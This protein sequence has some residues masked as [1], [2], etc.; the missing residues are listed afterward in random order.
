M[1]PPN[2]LAIPSP[3]AMRRRTVTQGVKLVVK[4][5]AKYI[6]APGVQDFVHSAQE[7]VVALKPRIL[8]APGVNDT[9]AMAIVSQIVGITRIIGGAMEQ[10]EAMD[11][12]VATAYLEKLR[13][14][15]EYLEE[16]KTE[17]NHHQQRPYSIKLA[18]HIDMAERLMRL[19]GKL[20]DRTLL[21]CLEKSLLMDQTAVQMHHTIALMQAQFATF[22]GQSKVAAID[23]ANEHR[24]SMAMLKAGMVALVAEIAELRMRTNS[25]FSCVDVLGIHRCIF[26]LHPTFSSTAWSSGTMLMLLDAPPAYDRCLIRP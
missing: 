25:R 15:T 12:A 10:L 4:P 9:H 2:E 6:G 26:F 1:L 21:L 22:Q 8:Q 16:T 13:P 18:L 19:E 5:L 14:F 11:V 3:S 17:I 20:R 23:S 24:E 7:L